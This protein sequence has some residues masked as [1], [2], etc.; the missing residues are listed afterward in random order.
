MPFERRRLIG[1]KAPIVQDGDWLVS[2]DRKTR[3]RYP[4]IDDI[5]VMLIEE[6]EVMAEDEWREVMKRHGVDAG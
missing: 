5:P 4:V 6:S 2:T 1:S 3:R